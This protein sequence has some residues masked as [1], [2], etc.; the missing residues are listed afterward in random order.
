MKDNIA[1]SKLVCL[2]LVILLSAACA[3]AQ[4]E[5]MLAPPT[6]TEATELNPSPRGYASMAYDSESD[7]MILFG[8]ELPG[9]DL[10]INDETWAYDVAS[11][12]WTEMKPTSGPP[13]RC[14]VDLV[15][16]SESDRIILF[17][18][19]S[20]ATRETA[21]VLNDTWAYDYNTNTWTEMAKGPGDLLGYR[22]AYDSESDR[23]ILFGGMSYP[24][25]NLYRRTWVYDF[26]T[27]TW[28]EMQP[29]ISPPARNY[30]A[31]AYDVQADRVILFSGSDFQDKGIVDTWA[32]DFNTNTW[33]ELE[34][35]EGEYPSGRFYHTLAYNTVADR[36]ILFG[37]FARD[38]LE[39]IAHETWLYDYSSNNWTQLKPV[40][41]PGWRT[42]HAMAYSSAADRIVLFGGQN[43]MVRYIYTD[44]TWVFDLNT[45]TW[46]DV[47]RRP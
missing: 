28:T 19:A 42:M 45:T 6:T 36:T 29:S 17:G 34:R 11:N 8:G 20:G 38:Q 10:K 44:D 30:H 22:M 23:S 25:F 41:N 32:Y 31:M 5:T 47:T 33:Q 13:P 3:T 21:S 16:D 26:N 43:V 1:A 9:E 37:G 12:T 39:G 40:E 35:G 2:I 14:A 4:P 24:G 46:T 18:G 15:Y 7:K 27:D